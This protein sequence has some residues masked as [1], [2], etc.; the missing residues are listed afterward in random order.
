MNCLNEKELSSYL[1]ENL[2][3][4]ERNRIERH[5][6]DCKKCL[7]M[8]IVAY[9]AG[10]TTK[11]RWDFRKKKDNPALKWL[12]ASFFLF[13]LSFIFKRFFLQFLIAGGILGFKWVMEGEG[14]RR[15]IMIFKGIE[16]K[17]KKFERKS[18]RPVSN[19]T[20]GDNY[21]EEQ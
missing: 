21:D 12:L 17:E 18:H 19:I 7:D 4:Q 3:E 1:D 5:L 14:A 6:S 13:A 15:A 9:D 2:S 10:K 16:K 8:L 20:G 11:R